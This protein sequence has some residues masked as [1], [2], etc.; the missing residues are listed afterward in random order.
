MKTAMLAIILISTLIVLSGCGSDP[1]EA[2]EAARVGD[3]TITMEDIDSEINRIP[4]YQRGAFESLRGRRTL[5]DH[6]IERELLILAAMDEGLEE[7]SM[8]LAMIGDTERQI[9]EVRSRAMGQVLYQTRIIDGVEIPDSL[10]QDYYE[11]NRDLYYNYPM[12]LVSHILVTSG[13]ALNQAQTMLA[14]G[15]PF[16]SVAVLLSEHS[17]TASSGGDMGWAGDNL[18]IPYISE[19]Q[20]LLA[21]LLAA[22]PGT[23]LPPYETNMGTHIFL[24]REQQP[25]SWDS[26][27]DVRGNIE[28][29]LRPALVNDYFRNTFLPELKEEYGVTVYEDPADGIYAVINGESITEEDV[30]AELEAIPPYQRPTYE[31]PE[32][33]ALVVNSMVERELMRLASIAEG[34]ESDSSVVAQ[35]QQ[36]E[37][38]AEET[39]KGAL[40]QAYYQKFVVEAVEVPEEKILEYY[41]AHTGDIYRQDPQT[42][43]SILV[44]EGAEDM[45]AALAAV[46]EGSF[47]DAVAEYSTHMPTAGS[48]GDLGWIPMNAPIPYISGDLDFF[49]SLH[50]AEPG[51]LFGPARTNQGLTLFMVT[52]RLE[53]GVKPLEEARESIEAALRPQMVNEYLYETIFPMLRERYQ[54]EINEAAFLPSESIGPDSLMTLAQET[55]GTDP[56]TAVEYFKLFIDRYPDNERCDQAQFLIGFTFS[57]QM[58]DYD[59]ARAAFRVLVETYPE[60]ELAD[61]AQWM[62]ENMEIPIEEFIP[63]DTAVEE[64]DSL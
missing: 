16:D 33:K 36:A 23:I 32:G 4:P 47:E 34:L 63:A 8:V 10:V 41:E 54:V 21:M 30:A 44:T 2:N 59:S 28:D 24:V 25:E 43:L 60:S 18:D 62:I 26:M 55:M 57:E 38:Q 52:D 42:R 61:D 29:M 35:V 58:R 7:D 39:L 17:A 46:E 40:I 48:G 20:E 31:T 51:T 6:I 37:R 3:R 9:E 53:E 13:E 19:D 22:E 1:L 15:T 5:L 64:P 14:E 49:D 56:A 11:R 12:A 50:T 45:D 27:E